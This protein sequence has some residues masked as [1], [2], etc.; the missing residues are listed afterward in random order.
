LKG[1]SAYHFEV[2]WATMSLQNIRN[3]DPVAYQLLPEHF[4][5]LLNYLCLLD[6]Q[7]SIEEEIRPIA[8]NIIFCS[9][10]KMMDEVQEASNPRNFSL[11]LFCKNR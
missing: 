4:R 1:H 9:E 3:K 2:K 10:Y 6:L 7:F 11:R 5:T 8:W